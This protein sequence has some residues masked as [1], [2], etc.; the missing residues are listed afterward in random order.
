MTRRTSMFKRLAL[1]AAI[2]A[3]VFIG[4]HPN[5]A[6]AEDK[7]SGE[8]DEKTNTR[9]IKV[10]SDQWF[11]KPST[12][13]VKAGEKVILN[14]D[15]R[16]SEI[17]NIDTTGLSFPDFSWRMNIKTFAKQVIELPAKITATPG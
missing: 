5:T 12:W 10:I 15:A 16:A 11:F 8:L 17:T 2:S 13:R 9:T 6:N 4:M 14:L 3:V 7:L 1:F